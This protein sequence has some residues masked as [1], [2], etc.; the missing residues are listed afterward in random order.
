MLND[1]LKAELVR[2]YTDVQFARRV[3]ADAGIPSEFVD[4]DGAAVNVWHQI[5]EQAERR[6]RIP[7]LVNVAMRDYPQSAILQRIWGAFVYG[8]KNE[9]EPAMPM[10]E[11]GKFEV[12]FKEVFQISKQVSE[13]R[14]W[15]IVLAGVVATYIGWSILWNG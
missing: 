4:F 12:L 8:P 1:D 3:C 9:T 5:V 7:N 14:V 10:S 6:H 15:V 13:L 11:D 2:L